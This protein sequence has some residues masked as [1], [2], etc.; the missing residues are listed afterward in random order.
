M[1]KEE[2]ISLQFDISEGGLSEAERVS[3][4][5]ISR[6]HILLVIGHTWNRKDKD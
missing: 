4:F 1:W 2:S 3:L 5:Y 6:I